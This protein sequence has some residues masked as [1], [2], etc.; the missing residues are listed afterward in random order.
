M[1]VRLDGSTIRPSSISSNMSSAT[2]TS[3]T[4]TTAPADKD[5]EES[6]LSDVSSSDVSNVD[7]AEAN[8][9]QQHSSSKL[10]GPTFTISNGSFPWRDVTVL[11]DNSP[12]YF[13]DVSQYT[14]RTPDMTWH[15]Q[16]KSG[17]VIGHTFIHLGRSIKCGL[18][19]EETSMTW[20]EMKRNSFFSS[21]SYTFEWQGKAYII[22]RSGEG[23]SRKSGQYSV[24]EAETK[25]V[26]AK[27]EGEFK[28]G[29]PMIRRTKRVEFAERVGE[30]LRVLVLMG[31][32]AWREK[33]R[34][35]RNA[36][37]RQPY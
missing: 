20:V 37:N 5:G 32:C 28:F 36:A 21:K 1:S 12:L 16:D 15:Y 3:T 33:S 35:K 6:R 7:T 27:H 25:E 23:G 14:A 31:V 26:V 10:N 18:G 2:T 22:C 24:L 19:S 9:T 34:R 13:A 8:N 11:S 30:E 17:P 4:L 29:S